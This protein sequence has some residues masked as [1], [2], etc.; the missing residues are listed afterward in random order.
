M[1]APQEQSLMEVALVMFRPDGRH[2][3]FPINRNQTVIGRG[4]QCDLRIPLGEVSRRHCKLS[5]DAAG[6]I[7]ADLGSSNGT[8]VNGRRI[9]EEDLD[10]GDT[11]K[12]GSLVFVVQLDGQPSVQDI[13]TD[14]TKQSPAV[15]INGPAGPSALNP[16]SAA[17]V[18]DASNG[19][20]SVSSEQLQF[21][22]DDDEDVIDLGAEEK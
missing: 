10:P 15:A 1:G 17:D 14:P 3:T 22:D 21:L 2:R 19:E 8:Y 16:T 6:I 4:E 7:V 5:V 12:I 13:N 18:G 20:A 11:I 9:Q